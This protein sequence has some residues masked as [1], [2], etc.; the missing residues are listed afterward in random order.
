MF[1]FSV[2]YN[3]IKDP[4]KMLFAKNKIQKT[5]TLNTETHNSLSLYI[6]KGFRDNIPL[7]R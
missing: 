6:N 1:S 3:S 7:I 5:D 2:F 4:K